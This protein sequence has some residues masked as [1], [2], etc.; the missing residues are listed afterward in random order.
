MI[1]LLLALFVGILSLPCGVQQAQATPDQGDIVGV[2]GD[3]E[4]VIENGTIGILKV[5]Y[6]MELRDAY[7]RV[8]LL[9]VTTNEGFQKLSRA[10][11]NANRPFDAKLEAAGLRLTL[12]GHPDSKMLYGHV[13]GSGRRVY[14]MPASEVGK[15]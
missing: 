1:R 11:M 4:L 8:E 12:R 6:L 7:G 3:A 9:I 13:T 10:M 14:V 2:S 15:K 5:Y